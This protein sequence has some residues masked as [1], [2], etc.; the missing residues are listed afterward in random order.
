MDRGTRQPIQSMGSQR[1]HGVP[2][3]D[4]HLHSY[5]I[6]SCLVLSQRKE[7]GLQTLPSESP[8]LFPGVHL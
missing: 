1:V 3:S 8:C 2:K 4:E 6:M 5:K 7:G